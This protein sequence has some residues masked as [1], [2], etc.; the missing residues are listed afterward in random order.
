MKSILE[1]LAGYNQWANRRLYEAAGALDDADYRADHG[2]FFGSVHRTLNHLLVADRI[3]LRRMTGEGEA[4]AHLDAILYDDFAELRA[5]RE[6]EDRRIV[7]YVASLS[8]EDLAGTIRYRTISN[9]A[10]IEQE[11]LPIVINFFNHQTHH[12]GQAHCML[13]RITNRAPS[14]DLLMYQ[15]ESGISLIGG[16]LGIPAGQ[17]TRALPLLL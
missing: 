3:W 12:R 11:L 16:P 5:A 15:R 7:A 4:P 17:Q 8:D 2:A 14:L 10:D 9:P 6:N 1:M 13:T